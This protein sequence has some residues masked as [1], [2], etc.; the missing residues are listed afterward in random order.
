MSRTVS[1]YPVEALEKLGVR[2][3]YGVAGDSFNGAADTQRW[4]GA[5]SEHST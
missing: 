2:R 3:I 5:V 4:S 1:E